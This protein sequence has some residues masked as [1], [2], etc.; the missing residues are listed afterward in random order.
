MPILKTAPA[1]QAAAKL[2]ADRQRL[3]RI[4]A[5]L[6]R[7]DTSTGTIA[8]LRRGDPAMVARQAAFYRLLARQHD[9]ELDHDTILRWAAAVQ[10]IAIAGRQKSDYRKG[11]G[12][13][14]AAAGYP[15]SR[16]ARLLA[17]RDDGYRDQAVLCARFLHS[18][19]ASS[20][21][22]E[23]AELVLTEGRRESRAERL[24]H[25][26]ARDYYRA[27]DSQAH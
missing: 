6:G 15:E 20:S 27:T 19:N 5:R 16:L 24:R 21:M 22:L 12:E 9:V 3:A 17:S 8:S 7:D 18:R 1:D 2:P 13:A 4:A 14:L 23:L 11:D 26:I 10:L 25:R